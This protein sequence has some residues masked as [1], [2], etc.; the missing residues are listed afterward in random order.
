MIESLEH[1]LRVK[2]QLL[3]VFSSCFLLAE[4]GHLSDFQ[5]SNWLK[6][7]FLCLFYFILPFFLICNT[8]LV[9]NLVF[10]LEVNRVMV[11]PY[12]GIFESHQDLNRAYS[13]KIALQSFV[14]HCF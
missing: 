1:A 10:K 6:T 3:Q 8:V 13:I 11:K 2:L 4:K 14:E 7:L 5:C 12:A 9:L